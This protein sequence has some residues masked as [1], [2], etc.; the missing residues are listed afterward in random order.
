[1]RSLSP[2]RAKETG[3]QPLGRNGGVWEGSVPLRLIL[4]G[5]KAWDWVLPDLRP[6]R[7]KSRGLDSTN[8]TGVIGAPSGH[9][10]RGRWGRRKGDTNW[11]HIIMHRHVWHK[12]ERSE[13]TN[14]EMNKAC[15][16]TTRASYYYFDIV[17]S[18]FGS[19]SSSLS[20]ASIG[21]SRSADALRVFDARFQLELTGAAI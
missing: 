18:S 8:G 21:S 11:L 14:K 9:T 2:R 16:E 12:R 13:T 3:D 10:A 1:M 17:S 6:S 4:V 7:V 15:C 20:S 5:R 19:S